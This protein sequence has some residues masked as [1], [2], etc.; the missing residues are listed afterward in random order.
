MRGYFGMGAERPGKPVNAGVRLHP[1]PAS[2]EWTDARAV[3]M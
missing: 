1:D 2:L 3:S